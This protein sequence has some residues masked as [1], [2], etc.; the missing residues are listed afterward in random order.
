MLL[1]CVGNYPSCQGR[2]LPTL[3]PVLPVLPVLLEL[4][5]VQ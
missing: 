1:G 3:L 5:S 2:Y 4:Q